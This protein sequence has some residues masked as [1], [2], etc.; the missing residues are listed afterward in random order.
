MEHKKPPFRWFMQDYKM[1]WVMADANEDVRVVFEEFHGY[2]ARKPY[3][4]MVCHPET[5]WDGIGGYT[6]P[7]GEWMPVKVK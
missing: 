2:T 4:V 6:I 7:Q 1:N 5:K 3:L